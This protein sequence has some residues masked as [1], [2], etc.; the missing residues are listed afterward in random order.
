MACAG[1]LDTR[2]H[3]VRRPPLQAR[4]MALLPFGIHLIIMCVAARLN[5]LASGSTPA[6]ARPAYGPPAFRHLSSHMCVAAGLSPLASGSTPA[7]ARPAHG[8]PVFRHLSSHMYVAAGL[9]Q[10]IQDSV[11][12]RLRRWTRN[13]LGSARRGLNPLAVDLLGCLEENLDAAL[14]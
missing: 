2:G 6:A 14:C 7:A 12:E 5:P 11:S 3:Q 1:W 9:N 8:P 4:P 10:A 13:P